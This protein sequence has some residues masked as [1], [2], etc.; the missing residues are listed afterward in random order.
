MDENSDYEL[1]DLN[2]PL[3]RNKTNPVLNGLNSDGKNGFNSFVVGMS[4][5]F[6]IEIWTFL[7]CSVPG[8]H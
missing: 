6:G 7:N 3:D 8:H 5:Y 1:S 4:K 2:P